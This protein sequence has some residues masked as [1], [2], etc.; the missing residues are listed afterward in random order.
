MIFFCEVRESFSTVKARPFFQLCLLLL[1]FSLSQQETTTTI[2]TTTTTTQKNESQPK[3]KKKREKSASQSQCAAGMM[4]VHTVETVRTHIA[5][6]GTQGPA[7]QFPLSLCPAEERPALVV[8]EVHLSQTPP[9][10]SSFTFLNFSL[11]SLLSSSLFF[12][13]FN[14]LSI[15]HS[16]TNYYTLPAHTTKLY[17]LQ[18]PPLGL[19]LLHSAPLPNAPSFVTSSL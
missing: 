12:L 7:L 1:P 2:T 3:T 10:P 9:P 4:Y 5:S 8:V 6:L 13:S 18:Q 11:F 19:Q 15:P 17:L 14:F 16:Q